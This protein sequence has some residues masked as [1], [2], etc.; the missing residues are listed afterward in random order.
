MLCCTLGTLRH[1]RPAC[2]SELKN[3]LML[4]PA[5]QS[6]GSWGSASDPSAASYLKALLHLLSAW[7]AVLF[8][9]WQW[10]AGFRAWQEL[11]VGLS[12]PA[13]GCSVPC[14]LSNGHV[15]SLLL[16]SPPVQECDRAY[17]VCRCTAMASSADEGQRVAS[18]AEALAEQIGTPPTRTASHWGRRSGMGEPGLHRHS[19]MCPSHS[20][21]LYWLPGLPFIPLA[22]KPADS[23]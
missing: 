17:R 21:K 15:V 22:E 20:H 16:T 3:G 14:N 12:G 4:T 8:A 5:L 23:L 7:P 18:T 13:D 6:S 19:P 1:L 9:L 11:G 2:A 10:P